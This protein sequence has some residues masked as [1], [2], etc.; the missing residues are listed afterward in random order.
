M[1]LQFF[2]GNFVTR[3]RETAATNVGKYGPDSSWL[4]TFAA[5]HVYIHESN[6]VVDPPPSL[7]TSTDK[8]AQ[9]DAENAKRI[10]SWLR[11]L[12]PA[13]AMEERLWAYLTHCAF[14]DYMYARWPA[15]SEKL[16]KRRYLFQ[17]KS[18]DA[19]ARNG[20][21]RLWWAGYLTS[22]EKRTNPFELTETLF[23]RQ[24]I[25]VSLLERSI[26]KCRNVRMCVLDFLRD[27]RS[28][29]SEEAFGKRIQVLLRELNLLGRARRRN[30]RRPPA[31]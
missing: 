5:G 18:F 14:P 11:M 8:N 9:N 16:V 10:F 27:N 23:L 17:S 28:G 19:L 26:G 3:L 22:D 1:K 15:V 20:I 12:T 29:L 13:L 21:A 30:P 4:E 25:Q 2:S 6:H 7:V 31:N 24:D